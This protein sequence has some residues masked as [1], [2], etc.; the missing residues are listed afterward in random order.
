MIES[1][2]VNPQ[3][4]PRILYSSPTPPDIQANPPPTVDLAERPV[5]R[6]SILSGLINEYQHT[7]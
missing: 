1:S 4:K 6:T 2:T 7:A 3:V 5:C